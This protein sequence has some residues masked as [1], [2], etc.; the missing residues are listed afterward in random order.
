MA[1]SSVDPRKDYTWVDHPGVEF[2]LA[3]IEEPV[4]ETKDPSVALKQLEDKVVM[5][6]GEIPNLAV[7]D[8]V[9]S[10][11][12]WWN[13][14]FRFYGC[15]EE[16]MGKV[17]GMCL[18]PGFLQRWNSPRQKLRQSDRCEHQRV[19]AFDFDV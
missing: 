8:L 10:L 1:N 13:V 5:L 11:H 19:R 17:K 18:A 15:G 2:I 16:E 9:S 3:W 7:V 12:S 6:Q 14:A 4:A